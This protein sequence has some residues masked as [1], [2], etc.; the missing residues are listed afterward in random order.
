[1]RKVVSVVTAPFRALGRL[2]LKLLRSLGRFGKPFAK[3]AALRGRARLV[4]LAVLAV[5]LVV[6]VITLKPGP[7][8]GK[9]VRETLDR[10][11]VASRDKDYQ[12]LC[13]ELLASELVEQIRRGGLPC[14]VALRI[15]LKDRRNPRLTVLAVEVNGDQALARTRTSAVAEPTS[16]DTIRLV[17]QDGRWRIASLQQPGSGSTLP[18]A[19]P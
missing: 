14:E 16:V 17:D 8:E 6:A 9:Q 7:D 15:G 4:A 1:M 12:A 10:Y 5:I 18:G 19:G 3:L 11:A 2:L 13:D